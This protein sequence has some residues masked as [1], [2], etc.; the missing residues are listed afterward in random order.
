M[1]TLG[2]HSRV[3]LV[4]VGSQR[5]AGSSLYFSKLCKA[6][7]YHFVTVDL[8]AE[9]TA[10]AET[11]VNSQS[12][13]F[14]A[15]NEYGEKYLE[16]TSYDLGLVYLDAFDID[17]T[18]HDDALR[19]WYKNKGA[20]L[21]DENCWKMHWDCAVAIAPKMVSKGFI[22]FDDVNPVNENGDLI[23]EKVEADHRLWSGKGTT[24]IPYLLDHGY[25]IMDNQRS[26]AILQKTA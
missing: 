2:Q 9:T 18:W 26:A 13:D 15:V 11:I 5:E 10:A 6:Q 3:T 8:N 25:E 14:E 21:N 20:D 16:S 23:L 19:A 24:A 1:D 22:V 4:E 7:G 12:P 17:G